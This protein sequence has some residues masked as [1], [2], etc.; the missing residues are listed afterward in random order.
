MFNFFKRSPRRAALRRVKEVARVFGSLEQRQKEGALHWDVRSRRLFIAEPLAL[1]MMRDK[2]TW[3]N[4]LTN[5]FLWQSFKRQQEALEKMLM[6]RESKAIREAKTKA[7]TLTKEETERIRRHV[8]DELTE[9]DV[10]DTKIEPYEVFIISDSTP[11][12]RNA[13][14]HTEAEARGQIV[15]VGQYDPETQKVEMALWEDVKNAIR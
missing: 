14:D 11:A 4:F 5:V 8:R 2:E 1:Y 12:R 15:A 7:V 9:Q 13:D 10:K 3:T 6:Q